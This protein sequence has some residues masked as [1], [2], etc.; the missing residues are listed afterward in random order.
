MQKTDFSFASYYGDDMVLQ[1][2]PN[3]AV[4]WGYAPSVARNS[5]VIVEISPG[6]LTYQATVTASVTWNVQIGNISFS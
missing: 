4:I 6:N 3:K 2:A 5:V 1:G